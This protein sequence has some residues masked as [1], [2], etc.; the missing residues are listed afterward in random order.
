MIY[1]NTRINGMM[2]VVMSVLFWTNKQVDMPSKHIIL[3]T[4]QSVFAYTP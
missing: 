2:M 3:I 4:S 1:Y